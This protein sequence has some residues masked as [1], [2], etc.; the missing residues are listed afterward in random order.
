VVLPAGS[1][2]T[3]S[4]GDG[5]FELRDVAP[6]DYRLMTGGASESASLFVA[7]AGDIDDLLL[8]PR[9]G[10][11][12]TG[13]VVTYSI[14]GLPAGIYLVVARQAVEEGEWE[15]REFLDDVRSDAVRIVLSAGRSETVDL[16]VRSR[17]ASIGVPAP[18]GARVT[19]PRRP[20]APPDT[21]GRRG[22]GR[23]RGHG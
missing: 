6:G 23:R 12:V 16:V 7:V 19:G 8:V 4:L 9:R 5:T 21:R 15:S 11:T 18:P 14:S 20:R 3:R 10:S 1:M 22:R 2:S 17:C 13:V